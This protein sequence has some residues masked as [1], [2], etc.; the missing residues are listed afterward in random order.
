MQT[1]ERACTLC[2]GMSEELIN[3]IIGIL[4]PFMGEAMA[5]ASLRVYVNGKGFPLSGVDMLMR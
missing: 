5:R 4:G 2:M 3:K 1:S